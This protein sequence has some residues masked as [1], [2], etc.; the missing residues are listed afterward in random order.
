M[1]PKPEQN[2]KKEKI[3]FGLGGQSIKN[4][5]M[6]TLEN[7]S[8]EDK[9]EEVKKQ[10]YNDSN[11]E[12]DIPQKRK[13]GRPKK[14]RTIEDKIDQE[15]NGDK[16]FLIRMNI[17]SNQREFSNEIQDFSS[18]QHNNIVSSQSVLNCDSSTV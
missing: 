2:G 5:L 15:T 16:N 10:Q 7:N 18:N 13:V 1:K 6:V 8:Q 4:H 14:R 12:E 3:E 11:Y 17:D 9:V